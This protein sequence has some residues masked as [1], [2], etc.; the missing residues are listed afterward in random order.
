RRCRAL[1]LVARAGRLR[2]NHRLGKGQ[3]RIDTGVRTCNA[4]DGERHRAQPAKVLPWMIELEQ[5]LV[6][7]DL[8]APGLTQQDQFQGWSQGQRDVLGQ[9]ELAS[10]G[11]QELRAHAA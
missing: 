7:R 2:A 11:C 1:W 5:R 4:R 6:E 3:R 9:L 8:A 10:V